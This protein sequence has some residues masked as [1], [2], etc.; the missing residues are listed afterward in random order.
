VK[1]KTKFKS[2][3]RY[4]S[5]PRVREIWAEEEN[6]GP[7]IWVSLAHGWNWYGCCS[8]HERSCRAIHG[9]MLSVEKGEA[10]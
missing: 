7:D 2:L 10:F 4:E 5:D 1:N 9:A 8:V 3:D 6:D